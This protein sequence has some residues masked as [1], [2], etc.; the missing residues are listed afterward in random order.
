M[1]FQHCISQNG[2]SFIGIVHWIFI[3]KNMVDLP[4]FPPPKQV[5]IVKR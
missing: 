3:E 4:F 5:K 1:K 2:V